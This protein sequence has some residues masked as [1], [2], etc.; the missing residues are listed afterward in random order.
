[1]KL[2]MLGLLIVGLVIA[3]DEG[4]DSAAK[5]ERQQ[6]EGSWTM[7]SMVRN[8]EKTEGEEAKK[9]TLVVDGDKYVLK[10]EDSAIG[11][12]TTKIDP[13]KTPKTIDIM[14][15]EGEN[16][17]KTEQGI[18]ELNG[19]DYK[20]CFAGPEGRRPTEFESKADS[21]VTYVIFKRAK[22]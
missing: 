11:R 3:A 9:F 12:G 2:R 15:S 6:L 13:S 21:G 7:V 10:N 17:G 22:K 14:P 8:G 20:I 5:K 1:M 4:K 18:Y 19:D 16:E